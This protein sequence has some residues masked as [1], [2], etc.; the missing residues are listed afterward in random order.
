MKQEVI[1]IEDNYWLGINRINSLGS[2]GPR[3]GKV[4]TVTETIKEYGTT[5]LV[6][7]EFNPDY[8]FN[9]QY[10][11]PLI[12]DDKLHKELIEILNPVAV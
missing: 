5:Y 9:A 7:A 12:S 3:K 10:F 8:A 1:C 11:A 4:Y 6:L 2:N